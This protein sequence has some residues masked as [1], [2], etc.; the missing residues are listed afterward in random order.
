MGALGHWRFGV[1]VPAHHPSRG[2]GGYDRDALPL[3]THVH[4]EQHRVGIETFCA[5]YRLDWQAQ[6][7]LHRARYER[8]WTDVA[9]RETKAGL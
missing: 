2:A 9:G 1:I 5:T 7:K 8:E 3:E 6:V 4:D